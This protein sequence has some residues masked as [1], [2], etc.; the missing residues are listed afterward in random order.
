MKTL[1]NPMLQLALIIVL[2]AMLFTACQKKQDDLAAGVQGVNIYLTD[3]PSFVFDN[4]Y[5][6]IQSVEIK[7][8]DSLEHNGSGHDGS[9]GDDNGGASSAWIKLQSRPG[10][11]DILKFRNGLDTLFSTGSVMS[12]KKLSK[13]RITLGSNN[14][15]VYNGAKFSLSL[16]K[17]FVIINLEDELVEQQNG[18]TVH[19]WLD[20]DAG[21]SIRKEGNQFVLEPKLKCFSK[22]KSGAI[23]G[24]VL[25]DAARA[26]VM[27]IN[28]TDTSTAKPEREGEFKIA[29]LKAGTYRLLVKATAGG[30]IDATVPN[31]VVR[32]K[33]DTNV[34]TIVLHQ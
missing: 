2:P 3:D 17:A 12:T 16:K 28:G 13:V 29:G 24:R 20:F 19:L 5:L 9:N 4:I 6:D 23:E 10:V 34:G 21:R 15:L 26:I 11:Y 32:T 7:M 1:K 8:K 33:D 18:G 30:Y 27:A 22:T 31:V 25:P 14:S